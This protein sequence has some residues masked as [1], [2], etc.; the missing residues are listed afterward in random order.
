MKETKKREQENKKK[1]GRGRRMFLFYLSPAEMQTMFFLSY[2]FCYGFQALFPCSQ[3]ALFAPAWCAFP[4]CFFPFPSFRQ[5]YFFPAFVIWSWRSWR[6]WQ[7]GGL[8]FLTRAVIGQ[9]VERLRRQVDEL[10]RYFLACKTWLSWQV[11]SSL[12]TLNAKT[13][14]SLG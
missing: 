11:P 7:V 3:T 13:T 14:P 1:S 4:L 6:S 10:Q 5:C 8:G 2:F 12:A 9:I